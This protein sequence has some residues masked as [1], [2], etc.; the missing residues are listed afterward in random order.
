MY[1][2]TYIIGYYSYHCFSSQDSST[3]ECSIKW[4]TTFSMLQ[5]LASKNK[6]VLTLIK[7]K[8]QLENTEPTYI[9]H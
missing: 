8:Y 6:I 4:S 2:H 5:N 1:I 9:P 7:T 3:S